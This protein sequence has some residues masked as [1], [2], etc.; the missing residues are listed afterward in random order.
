M[1]PDDAVIKAL[2]S[3]L[4]SY[5]RTIIKS[6]TPTNKTA[7]LIKD[8]IDSIDIDPAARGLGCDVLVAYVNANEERAKSIISDLWWGLDIDHRTEFVDKGIESEDTILLADYSEDK[9]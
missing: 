5:A 6:A 4:I 1:N 3:P 7:A 8:K 9:P 2:A